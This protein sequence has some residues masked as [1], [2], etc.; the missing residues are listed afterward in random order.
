VDESTNK[1]QLIVVKPDQTEVSIRI[2]DSHDIIL[3]EERVNFDKG[4]KR[5]YDLSKIYSKF[6]TFEVVSGPQSQLLTAK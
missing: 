3:H 2:R 5:V 6:Y 1:F 4:F